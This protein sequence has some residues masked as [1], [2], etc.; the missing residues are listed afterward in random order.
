MNAR[1]YLYIRRFNSRRQKLVADDKLLTKQRLIKAGVPTNGI[2]AQFDTLHDVRAFDW[3]S[4]PSDFAIKPAHGYGGRGIVIVRD[5]NGEEGSLG[6]G[7]RGDILELERVIFGALDGE[8]SLNNLPDSAFIE[9]RIRPHSF[10]K[11]YTAKGVPDLRII[12]CNMVPVMAMMRLPT[13]SSDGKANLHLGA[14]GIG[15]DIRTGITTSAV[16]YNRPVLHIPGT[17]TKV[18]GI[19]IPDWDKILEISVRA[20]Q[21]SKLGYAGVDIVLDDKLGPLVLEI[22]ARP[23]LGI[24]IANQASL[25]TRLE[26][27]GDLKVGTVTR[28]VELAKKLFAEETLESV[29]E[30]Q[31]AVLGVIERI[32]IYGNDKKRTVRAKVDTGAYRTSIDSALVEELGLDPHHKL[33]Q[34]RSGSGRQKRRTVKMHFKMKGKEIDT[35]ATYTPRGHLRFPVIIGRK[36]MGGFLVDPT[37]IPE[38]VLVR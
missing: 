24:Q 13:I 32:T 1:N 27:I 4:L 20:Q 23:G 22:N 29:N 26:R 33:V 5:W 25:R 16:L 11:K 28:A 12:V 8:H 35:I 6:G 21:C 7:K 37:D 18:H 15:I 30:Q 14:L 17:K 38:G 2:L 36:D 3:K 19:R 9:D 34:V 10:F 31:S